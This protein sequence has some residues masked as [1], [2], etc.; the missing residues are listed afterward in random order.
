M[1]ALRNRRSPALKPRAQAPTRRGIQARP[2][3]VKLVSTPPPALS[4]ARSRVADAVRAANV[5]DPKGQRLRAVLNEALTEEA[6]ARQ[7]LAAIHDQDRRRLEVWSDAATG[8]APKPDEA[9]RRVAELRLAAAIEA[10]QLAVEASENH[11]RAMEATRGQ[12][13]A[14]L[15]Q[16]PAAVLAVLEEEAQQLMREMLP[17]LQFASLCK[18]RL[19]ALRNHALALGQQTSSTPAFKLGEDIWNH[20]GS[21][22]NEA[23]LSVTAQ[24]PIHD[25]EIKAAQAAWRDFAEALPRDPSTP[26]PFDTERK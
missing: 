5:V 2:T 25:P 16:L 21:I 10:H 20:L 7:E 14:A 12:A 19:E 6:A 11:N 15:A 22:L 3:A 4:P 26:A 24:T 13:R 8:A 17:A 18:R 23:R 1:P 9:T